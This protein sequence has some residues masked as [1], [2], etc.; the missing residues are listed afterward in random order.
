MS[1]RT[2]GGGIGT[3]IAVG[4]VSDSPATLSA[5][6]TM[7]VST[8]QNSRGGRFVT[9]LRLKGQRR[10]STPALIPPKASTPNVPGD[11]GV[12]GEAFIASAFGSLP[13]PD[14]LGRPLTCTWTNSSGGL[15]WNTPTIKILVTMLVFRVTWSSRLKESRD[16]L[17]VNVYKPV[18][19][20][21]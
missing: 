8:V 12:N 1:K 11:S 17:I 18:G 9:F 2:N 10:V 4:G 16:A 15:P 19:N 3:G 13:V 7:A 20:F 6:A 21:N 14:I 5:R